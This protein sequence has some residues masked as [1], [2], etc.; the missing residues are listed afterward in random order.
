MHFH[1]IKL[2]CLFPIKFIQKR[3]F[4]TVHNIFNNI[5]QYNNSFKKYATIFAISESVKKNI[6]IKGTNKIEKKIILIYNGI[7][8]SKMNVRVDFKS[9]NKLKIVQ[10]SR[11]HNIQKGQDVLIKALKKLKEKYN[12]PFECDFIGEGKD[13]ELLSELTTSLNLNNEI[14][15]LGNKDR[16]WVYE[17]LSEYHILVQ[18][19]LSEGFGLTV[20]EGLAAGIPVISSNIEG[21]NEI[22][23]NGKYGFVFD[24][25]NSGLLADKIYEVYKLI[26]AEEIEGH[27]KAS[28]KYALKNFSIDSTV[29][30]YIKNYELI[31]K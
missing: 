8:F 4:V 5:G 26:L 13:L 1:D 24:S 17:N 30:G 27:V 22:L 9:L 14:K 21:P 25:E 7:D 12:I 10:I 6:L 20:V 15:F 16:G 2:I 11:L 28:Y 23:D 31:N 19:S 3:S 29:N 18:P